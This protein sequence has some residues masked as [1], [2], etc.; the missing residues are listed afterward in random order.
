MTYKQYIENKKKQYVG[1]T[2]NYKGAMYTVVDI[3]Y[4]GCLIIDK[5]NRFNLTTA[6]EE[7][8]ADIEYIN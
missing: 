8:D 1:K 3:D 7:Y 4:N 6:V 2:V 5:P